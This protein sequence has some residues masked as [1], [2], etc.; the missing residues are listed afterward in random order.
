MFHQI[1]ETIVHELFYHFMFHEER[2]M[3]IPIVAQWKQSRLISMRIRFDPWPR[4][5]LQQIVFIS[6]TQLEAGK[7][8]RLRLCHS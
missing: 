2:K 3:G 4:Y 1:K 6:L 8:R 7:L 5:N